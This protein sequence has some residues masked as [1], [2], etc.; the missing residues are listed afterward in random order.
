S[1]DD[2][3]ADDRRPRAED[4][5][6]SKGADTAKRPATTAALEA[7]EAPRATAQAAPRPAT[8]PAAPAAAAS[9]PARATAPAQAPA[10]S[11]RP[12]PAMVDLQARVEC[13]LALAPTRVETAVG[14]YQAAAARY[15]EHQPAL[16]PLRQSLA[17][18]G[19]AR[20]RE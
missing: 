5:L 4:R 11:A 2:A 10:A 3:R 9:V 18:H 15:G 6:V 17:Q 16:T 20:A 7:Q 19:E 1:A 12:D 13:A 8:P 14:L